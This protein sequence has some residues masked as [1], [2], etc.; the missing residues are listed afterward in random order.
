MK[1]GLVVI[2]IIIIIGIGIYN[3]SSSGKIKDYDSQVPNYYD[4][5][6]TNNSNL[7]NSS[8]YKSNSSS[9]SSYKSNSSSNKSYNPA[10]Y[11][12]YGNYKPVESMTQ[13]EKRQEL[14]EMLGDTL[15]GW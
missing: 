10:D 4:L 2:L 11:D 3:C 7:T 8:S 1:K 12:K 9:S 14:K 5:D 6:N 15:K 13:E